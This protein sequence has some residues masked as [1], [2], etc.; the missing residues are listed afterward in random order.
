MTHDN[1]PPDER[2]NHDDLTREDGMNARTPTRSPL[3]NR[4]V[5]LLPLRL[6]YNR[7][8]NREDGLRALRAYTELADD[9]P[10]AGE[11]H[12]ARGQIL[13]QLSEYEQAKSAFEAARAKDA[14]L[15]W[16]GV[17]ECWVRMGEI[18]EA[19]QAYRDAAS[20]FVKERLKDAANDALRGLGVAAPNDPAARRFARKIRAMFKPTDPEPPASP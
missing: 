3:Q 12:H 7:T 5:D 19:V 14:F 1:L 9:F 8:G 13:F 16:L 4:L 10:D 6:T 17:A 2:P 20:H 11:P 15:G 18:D